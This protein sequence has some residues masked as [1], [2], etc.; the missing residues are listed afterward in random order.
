MSP[1]KLKDSN[2]SLELKALAVVSGKKQGELAVMLNVTESH[3]SRVITQK[4]SASA[5]L[6][7]KL[8]SLEIAFG[9]NSRP[10]GVDITD[11]LSDKARAVLEMIAKVEGVS[12][13]EA[14]NQAIE[15]FGDVLLQRVRQKPELIPIEKLEQPPEKE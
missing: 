10:A 7:A 2:F 12:E 14:M 15:E 4:R 3:L 11:L 6:W 5:K 9:I 13:S 1:D 8:E